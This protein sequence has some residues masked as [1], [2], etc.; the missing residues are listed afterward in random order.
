MLTVT[1]PK[2]WFYPAG[3]GTLGF[4]LPTAIGAKL[5]APQRAGATLIGD[6]GFQYT[7]QELATA[8]DHKLPLI[9][10]LWNNEGLG[11]IAD[12]M[13][14]ID[15]E[16]VEVKPFNP[17]F[18]ALAEAYGCVATCPDSKDEFEQAVRDG[19][20]LDR[21]TFIEVKQGARWLT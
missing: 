9:I 5:A 10:I 1:N 2:S 16:P 11:E 3:Y 21:P 4:A 14:R 12:S 17:D 18:L 19:L 7:L 15:M 6:Y 20:Q 13:K 8:V